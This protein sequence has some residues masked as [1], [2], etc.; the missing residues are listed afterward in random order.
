M[1][2]LLFT[3]LCLVVA[4]IV[5]D[6]IYSRIVCRYIHTRIEYRLFALRDRLRTIRIANPSFDDHMFRMMELRINGC[7]GLVQK[8]SF[9]RL[10]VAVFSEPLTS[11]K[12]KKLASDMEASVRWV[13]DNRET[14][15]GKQLFDIEKQSIRAFENSFSYNSP[16]ITLLFYCVVKPIVRFRPRIAAKYKKVK[17]SFMKNTVPPMM[18]N[19]AR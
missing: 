2:I 9:H 18:V 4:W 10:V 15:I 5:L 7:I 12:D 6:T 3:L 17:D 1:N 19:A 14:E 11:E 16:F 13:I 8:L